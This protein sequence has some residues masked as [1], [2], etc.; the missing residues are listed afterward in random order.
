MTAAELFETYWPILVTVLL[1]FSKFIGDAVHSVYKR[2]DWDF[3]GG[4]LSSRNEAELQQ[5]SSSLEH[6]QHLDESLLRHTITTNTETHTW[7]RDKMYGKVEFV[8]DT[9]SSNQ[10]ILRN[11][12]GRQ[13]VTERTLSAL[14][15]R[16]NELR[17]AQHQMNEWVKELAEETEKI[18]LAMD[19]P[20]RTNDDQTTID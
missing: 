11:M 1:F 17:L 6:N 20:E 13:D 16:M 7:L 5:Q 8:E 14:V 12:H 3:F 19:I 10:A 4:L 2:V 18:V 15:K 9:V